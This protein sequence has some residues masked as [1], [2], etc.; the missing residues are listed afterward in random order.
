[1]LRELARALPHDERSFLAVK[2]AGP[3]RWQ[4]YGERVL[5]ITTPAAR[6]RA[7]VPLATAGSAPGFEQTPMVREHAAQLPLAIRETPRSDAPP[8]IGG[9]RERPAPPA[10]LETVWRLCASG[11]TLAQIAERTR[12]SSADVARRL[13]ELRQAGRVLDVARLLGPERVDAIRAAA[14]GA[15]G[16]LAGG[17]PPRG[18]GALKRR[19][20]CRTPVLRFRDLFPQRQSWRAAASTRSSW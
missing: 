10:Q 20:L 6:L 18:R 12:L 2:G 1:M 14:R 17:D 3:N 5:A 4:R 19:L 16:D 13:C 8:P 9:P 7:E 15:N 11:A